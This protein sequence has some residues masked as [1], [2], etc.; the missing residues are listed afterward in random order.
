[1]MKI[2]AIARK[3]LL[4]T[5][6]DTQALAFIMLMPI[7]LIFA[8]GISLNSMFEGS[9][10]EVS[11]F[12]VGVI[13][14][15]DGEAATAVMDFVDSDDAKEYFD[16]V[17][18]TYDELK[19]KLKGEEI[20]A[21]LQIPKG[22]SE[23]VEQGEKAELKI[24]QED[25]ED[26]NNTVFSSVI[27]GYADANNNINAAIAAADEQLAA[28]S[29]PGEAV[30]EQLQ[31]VLDSD[32]DYTGT[33]YLTDTKKNISAIQYYS[34]AMAAM[35]ILFVGMIGT[36][37]II[38]ERE[39]NTLMR[40]L[41]TKASRM[42]IVLG[43]FLG[44]FLIGLLDLAIIILFSRFAFGVRWGDSIGGLLLLST[45]LSFAASGMALMIAT[46][47]KSSKAVNTLNPVIIMV[48]GFIGGNMIPIYEMNVNFQKVGNLLLNTWGMK[49]YLNLMINNGIQSVLLPSGVLFGMG[50]LFLIIGIP[51]LRLQ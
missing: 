11:K 41:T 50:V 14:E 37:S 38:E 22:Y 4:V 25:E 2:L 34:A 12:E 24:F 20:V 13:N 36:Q 23:A 44:L 8:L 39:N 19:D 40:L 27:K 6:K 16:V 5:L 29:I 9:S 30:M 33:E 31:E 1:M 32:V 43:K 51:R 46:L 48:M 21:F 18:G 7:V 45:T 15:D 3:E 42:D 47:F 10:A 35:Y 17:T 28:Y 26:I 49:G